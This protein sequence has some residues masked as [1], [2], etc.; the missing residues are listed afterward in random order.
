MDKQHYEEMLANLEHFMKQS[1]L[2]HTQVYLF[3]HCNATEVLAEELLKHEVSIQAILDNN[4]SKHGTYYRTIPIVSPSKIMEKDTSDVVVFIVARA[5]ASMV[6]QLKQLGFMG[7]VKKLVDYNSYAEYSLSPKT[8]HDKYERML[9]G[10]ECLKQF[11]QQY[12]NHFFIFCPFAALGDVYYTMSYLPYFLE[13]RNVKQAV[14]FTIGNACADVVRMFGGVG[15]KILTQK[16]MDE[17]IQ[18]VLYLKDTKSYIPHQDRPYVIY[19]YKALYVKKIPFEIIYKCGV[20]GLSV[21]TQPYRPSHLKIYKKLDS[22]PYKHSVILSPYA[23]SVTTI[24]MQCW[25]EIV[26]YYAE[27]GYSLYTN[28]TKEE[29]ELQGTQRLEVPLNEMQSVVEHAGIFIGLRSGLC[30]VIR[31]ADCEKIALYP[32]VF[33]SDTRWKMEEIYHLDGWENIVVGEH[34]KWKTD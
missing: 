11:R 33:Y 13:E 28:V 32:D 6:K 21:D 22:I 10:A 27:K 24:S 18:A 15:S 2:K 3:G 30:D 26:S 14:V 1:N 34:F 9:R 19:L 25:S 8:I 20:F 4:A 31:Y 12:K 17:T 29:E 16:Q 23:K 5:Y 7:E